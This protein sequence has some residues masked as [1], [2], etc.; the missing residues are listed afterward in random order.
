MYQLSSDLFP[1]NVSHNKTLIPQ[2]FEWAM[3]N[4]LIIS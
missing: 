4:L 1:F 2:K 3:Q